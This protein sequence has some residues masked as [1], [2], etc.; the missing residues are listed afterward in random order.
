MINKFLGPLSGGNGTVAVIGAEYNFSVSRILWSPRS[1][2]GDA[3]DL[4]VAI[5]GMLTRTLSSGDPSYK[6]MNGYYVGAE[7][8]YR[9]TSLFSLTLQA[10]GEQRGTYLGP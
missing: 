4:R 6:G 1:F 5:A 2:T 3:A 9:M 10:Y 8:E 7:T